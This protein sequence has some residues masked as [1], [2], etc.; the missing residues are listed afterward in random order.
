VIRPPE[1]ARLSAVDHGAHRAAGRVAHQE[2][3]GRHRIFRH[4]VGV[5]RGDRRR[6]G[7][8]GLAGDRHHRLLKKEVGVAF[9][10]FR[11]GQ[12]ERGDAGDQHGRKQGHEADGTR[13]LFDGGGHGAALRCRAVCSA[14]MP[15]SMIGANMLASRIANIVPA[16]QAEKEAIRLDIAPMKAP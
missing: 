9:D 16:G 14:L 1:P 5:P 11:R 10:P 8:D 2:A 6:I 7:R 12:R 15:M 3:A 13:A 4:R